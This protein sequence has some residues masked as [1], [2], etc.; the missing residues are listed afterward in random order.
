MACPNF[1]YGPKN[2]LGP[3]GVKTKDLYYYVALGLHNSAKIHC[4]FEFRVGINP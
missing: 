1:K 4:S 3:L 2:G